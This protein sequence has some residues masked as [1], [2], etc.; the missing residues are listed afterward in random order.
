M[1]LG[2]LPIEVDMGDIPQDLLSTS[3]VELPPPVP[4]KEMRQ[5]TSSDLNY[6]HRHEVHKHAAAGESPSLQIEPATP[7]LPPKPFIG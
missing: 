5:T 6:H 3:A 4:P 2:K 7:P 1:I